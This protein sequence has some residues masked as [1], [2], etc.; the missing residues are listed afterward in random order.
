MGNKEFKQVEGK[1]DIATAG[2][3]IGK[4]VIEVENI[5]KAY[6]DRTLIKDFTY[7]LPPKIASVLLAV[8]G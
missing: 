8:T 6:G 4:K 2:R 5:S 3:R 7:I 1:V